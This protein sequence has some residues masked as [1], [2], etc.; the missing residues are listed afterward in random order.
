V[1]FSHR[2]VGAH[3]P[4][5]WTCYACGNLNFSRRTTCNKC[6]VQRQAHELVVKYGFL[7]KEEPHG[8]RFCN[9]AL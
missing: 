6:Q 2:K 1:E 3:R 4:G 8:T 7:S 9:I 5:E